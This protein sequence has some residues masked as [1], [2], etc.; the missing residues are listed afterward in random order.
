MKKETQK[1]EQ[2]KKKEEKKK[3]IKT[4][5]SIEIITEKERFTLVQALY[6]YKHSPPTD[7]ELKKAYDWA[8]AVK[9][10]EVL[11]ENVF[12]GNLCMGFEKG[13]DDPYFKATEEAREEFE[14]QMQKFF[15]EES[16]EVA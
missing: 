13:N 6:S 2:K 16:R 10:N 11:F 5:E 9:F 7:E 14:N 8:V 4:E 3:T 1:K 15:P 12:N